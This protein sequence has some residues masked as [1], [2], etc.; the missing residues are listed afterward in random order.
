MIVKVKEPIKEEY[1]LIKE[2]QLLFTYFHFASGEELT[3]AR[4]R[5]AAQP[6]PAPAHPDERSGWAHGPAAGCQVP[7]EATE[8]PGHSAGRDFGKMEAGQQPTARF[9]VRI[10]ASRTWCWV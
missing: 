10:P 5:G 2:G 4:N 6:G 9:T 1:S 7:G 3:H 8:R